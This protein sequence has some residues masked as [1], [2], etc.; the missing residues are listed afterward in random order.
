MFIGNLQQKATQ[1]GLKEDA[2]IPQENKK[3]RQIY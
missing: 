3:D 2:L 1:V